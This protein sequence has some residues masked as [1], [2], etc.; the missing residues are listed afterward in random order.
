M[1]RKVR[2]MKGKSFLKKQTLRLRL[3]G[4]ARKQSSFLEK[5]L[6]THCSILA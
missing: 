1:N 5:E 2:L 3:Q 4:A 6:A